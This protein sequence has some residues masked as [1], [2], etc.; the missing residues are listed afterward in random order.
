LFERHLEML[1]AFIAICRRERIDLVVALSPLRAP[2]AD[3]LDGADAAEAVRRIAEIVSVW[4]FGHPQ[5]LSDDPQLW[6][7]GSHY[8]A[9]VGAMMLARIY[10]GAPLPRH[11][12]FGQLRN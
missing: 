2:V 11:P 1:R 12:D 3:R 6:F 8:T 5:W 10:G 4:D 7:D 9:E